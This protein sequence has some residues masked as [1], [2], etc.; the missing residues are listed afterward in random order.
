MTRISQLIAIVGGV[1]KE[2]DDHLAKLRVLAGQEALMSG[3]E[4][5]YRPLDEENGV[6]LP[7]KSQ[8]VRMTAE[9]ILDAANDLLTRKWDISRTLDTANAVAKANIIVDGK[10]LLVDVPVGHC[11]YLERELSA[12]QALVDAMPT[13][14]QTKD[15][16]D[17]NAEPG[18]HNSLPVETPSSD[19]VAYNW[20][21]GNGTVN[22]K[23]DVDV[24]FH[25]VVVGY[26]T[27]VTKSGAF[28]HKRKATLIT[29]ISELRIAVKTAREE[30][31]STH[32]EDQ[33]E[34]KTIFVWL[35]RP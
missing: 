8:R 34:G 6:K 22:H 31:N 11:L 9:E 18:Q 7:P 15:W 26:W 13:L 2:A 27:T 5:T 29:R 17:R 16:D 21:R 14:D 10:I 12:L 30:A 28:T 35:L 19:K 20:P 23:E 4:K 32:V 33:H 25:D 1:T 3:L 24:L